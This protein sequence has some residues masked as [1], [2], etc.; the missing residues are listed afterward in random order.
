[1]FKVQKL[2]RPSA[3]RDDI[4]SYLGSRYVAFRPTHVEHYVKSFKREDRI[5]PITTRPISANSEA[6][7][8]LVRLC[9]LMEPPAVPIA[10][11][12]ELI[13]HDDIVDSIVA[14]SRLESNSATIF[15]ASYAINRQWRAA[16]LR[17]LN[18][19]A[20]RPLKGRVA[21]RRVLVVCAGHSISWAK[22]V[23]KV[24][25]SFIVFAGIDFLCR[26]H[27]WH[28]HQD[29]VLSTADCITFLRDTPLLAKL[30]DG[31]VLLDNQIRLIPAFGLLTRAHKHCR[32]GYIN[33][34]D[35]G[36]P[37]WE[38]YV[39]LPARTLVRF[40]LHLV[41]AYGQVIRR[42]SNTVLTATTCLFK[43][44]TH[45]RLATVGAENFSLDELDSFGRK[46]IMRMVKHKRI[47]EQRT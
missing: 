39:Q 25:N 47:F 38:E 21:N 20:Y 15:P 11:I 46:T 42:D 3:T 9:Q 45:F 12:P 7:R 34:E 8:I 10:D 40:A 35:F 18:S 19:A 30:C 13:F 4:F 27:N 26:A 28:E 2:M 29:Y 31:N 16:W 41:P 22:P 14:S 37:R 23:R 17:R 43:W 5:N 36:L 24:A 33:P 32:E 6:H 44:D 1:M